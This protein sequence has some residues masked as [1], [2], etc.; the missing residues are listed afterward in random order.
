MSFAVLCVI[1]ARIC[2]KRFAFFSHSLL[3]SFLPFRIHY[4]LASLQ[5]FESQ[6]LQTH[7]TK[8]SGYLRSRVAGSRLAKSP[9]DYKAPCTGF[10]TDY[11]RSP[12]FLRATA[13]ISTGISGRLAGKEVAKLNKKKRKKF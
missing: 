5:P 13:V 1:V 4:L 11:W 7:A 8:A 2:I 6:A 12:A 9:Q 10:V 3:Q